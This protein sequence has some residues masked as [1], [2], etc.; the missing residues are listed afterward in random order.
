MICFNKKVSIPHI[1]NTSYDGFWM[2]LFSGQRNTSGFRIAQMGVPCTKFYHARTCWENIPKVP[3]YTQSVGNLVPEATFW[4]AHGWFPQKNGKNPQVANRFLHDS[5]VMS[6][7][8]SQ[9]TLTSPE[10]NACTNNRKGVPRSKEFPAWAS[11][12]L[13]S[14]VPKRLSQKPQFHWFLH[15]NT[16]MWWWAMHQNECAISPIDCSQT[17]R[18]PFFARNFDGRIEPSWLRKLQKILRSSQNYY[19]RFMS[20]QQLSEQGIRLGEV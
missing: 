14:L 5:D 16:V 3:I 8:Q 9:I 15:V 7:G 18:K 20:N 4:N 13:V 2:S 17:T 6:F 12:E 11:V 10:T 19:E 1:F